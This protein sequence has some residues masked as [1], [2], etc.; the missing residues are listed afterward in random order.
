MRAKVAEAD[1]REEDLR[2]ALNDA[3]E[4]NRAKSEFLAMMSHELRTPLNAILGFSE[5]IHSLSFGNDIDRYRDYA[6]DIHRAGSHLLS[7]IN[8][9]LDLSKAESGKFELQPEANSV[10][11]IAEDALRLVTER[12]LA[13]GV[14]LKTELPALP[15]LLLDRLRFKQILL[16]LLSNAVKFTPRGGR[17]MLSGGVGPDDSVWLS[18]SDTGIGMA[19]DMIPVALEAFRQVNSSRARNVEGTG[20][21]LPLTKALVEL[22]GGA[23]RIESWL[24]VGTTVTMEFPAACRAHDRH[25]ALVCA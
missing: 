20:L 13:A 5:I 2:V 9:I 4:A 17:V 23:I 18:L 8:D 3:K 19:P 10:E 14:A 16:N 6:G 12:A 7:L 25:A 21:G 15:A 22:H 11:E 1:I 24:N